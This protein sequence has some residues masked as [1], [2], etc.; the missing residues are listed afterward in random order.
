MHSRALCI[1]VFCLYD[2]QLVLFLTSTFF[3]TKVLPCIIIII[4][5]YLFY[6]FTDPRKI[7]MTLCVHIIMFRFISENVEMAVS[8][9]FGRITYS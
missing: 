8:G 9:F 7:L 2:I 4:I 1:V 3:L 5:I 6:S